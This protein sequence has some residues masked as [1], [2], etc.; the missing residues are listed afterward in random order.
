MGHIMIGQFWVTYGDIE[1]FITVILFWWWFGS[2]IRN[3]H[4]PEFR[5]AIKAVEH[6]IAP[7]LSL[8]LLYA[9]ITGLFGR[10]MVPRSILISMALWGLGLL[11]Y[12]SIRPDRKRKSVGDPV[13][14]C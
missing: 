8:A 1:Y 6:V 9:S 3:D 11:Y 10:S 7:L 13:Q 2:K 5:T 12:A 14:I 4:R